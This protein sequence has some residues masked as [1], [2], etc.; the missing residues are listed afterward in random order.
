MD[1]VEKRGCNNEVQISGEV[2]R[3]IQT[4]VRT[5]YD[6]LETYVQLSCVLFTWL[7]TH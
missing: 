1:G 2:N 7:D 3:M 5:I 6:R 4:E